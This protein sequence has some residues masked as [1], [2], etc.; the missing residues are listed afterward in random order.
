[1]R[2][3]SVKLQKQ[4]FIQNLHPL[5]S[6]CQISFSWKHSVCFVQPWE[7]WELILE[8]HHVWIFTCVKEIWEPWWSRAV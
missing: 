8:W 2:T 3:G 7:T 6:S 1:M 5:Y 4:H